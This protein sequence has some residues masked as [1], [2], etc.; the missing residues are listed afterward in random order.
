MSNPS[1]SAAGTGPALTCTGLVKGFKAG[2]RH[3][4]ALD[5]V[6]LNVALGQVTG[7]IGP[8]GAGKTTFMRRGLGCCA[9]TS[10]R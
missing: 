1:R 10:G 6:T 2:G 3:I 5:G 9:P 7:L 4:Q 8:D